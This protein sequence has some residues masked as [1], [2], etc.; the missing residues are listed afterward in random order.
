[1]LATEQLDTQLYWHGMDFTYM[2]ARAD[3]IEL[4][5]NNVR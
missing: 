2:I 4:N 3:R 5:S 1:M